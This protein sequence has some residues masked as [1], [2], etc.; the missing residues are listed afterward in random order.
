[1]GLPEARRNGEPARRT[2]TTVLRL[3]CG[4]RAGTVLEYGTSAFDEFVAALEVT[5]KPGT[6]AVVRIDIHQVGSSCGFSM[7]R[8]DF[9]DF[10]CV[11]CLPLLCASTSFPCRRQHHAPAKIHSPT[12]D[13][14]ISKRVASDAAGRRADGLEHYWSVHASCLSHPSTYRLGLTHFSFLHSSTGPT[15]TPTPWMVCLGCIGGSRPHTPMA[16]RPSRRW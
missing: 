8:Y 3:M 7:P 16:S 15:R 1:M 5:L 14:F 12:L 2:P 9:K 13:D 10:R 4:A 11:L 6:R